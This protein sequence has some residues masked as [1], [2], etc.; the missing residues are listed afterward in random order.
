M[1]GELRPR[2]GGFTAASARNTTKKHFVSSAPR[3]PVFP[4]SPTI[5][6][7]RP[8]PQRQ[9]TRTVGVTQSISNDLEADF[10]CLGRVHANGLGHERLVGFPCH[11]LHGVY[12]RSV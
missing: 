2:K 7:T 6:P 9:A 1:R 10:P 11:G 5:S 4:L 12:V 8:A 3:L